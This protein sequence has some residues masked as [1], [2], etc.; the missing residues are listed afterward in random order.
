[1]KIPAKIKTP[2]RTINIKVITLAASHLIDRFSNAHISTPTLCNN[3]PTRVNSNFDPATWTM[4]LLGRTR[5]LSNSPVDT[6][7]EKAS[8]PLAKHSLIEKAICTTE[9][10]KATSKKLHPYLKKAPPL[11]ASKPVK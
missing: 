3:L 1:M 11:Y 6:R 8:N 5:T 2:L 7:L 4:V 10:H 9:K